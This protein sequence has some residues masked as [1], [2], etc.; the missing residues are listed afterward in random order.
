[1]T[2]VT[3]KFRPPERCGSGDRPEPERVL[4][5][6]YSL[7]VRSGFRT[8]PGR[9]SKGFRLGRMKAVENE[10]SREF[11]PEATAP[12]YPLRLWTCG[13]DPHRRLAF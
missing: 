5:E 13:H 1:M 9:N 11:E 2:Q 3:R 4:P 12:E 10:F 7:R 8:E 6:V